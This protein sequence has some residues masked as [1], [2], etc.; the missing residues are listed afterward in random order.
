MAVV[1]CSLYQREIAVELLDPRGKNGGIEVIGKKDS[2]FMHQ[3][4]GPEKLRNG[5]RQV[6][7]QIDGGVIRKREIWRIVIPPVSEIMEIPKV[8]FHTGRVSLLHSKSS[9]VAGRT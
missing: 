2:A 6:R 3:Q 1:Y 7:G 9:A 5:D 8:W 4:I